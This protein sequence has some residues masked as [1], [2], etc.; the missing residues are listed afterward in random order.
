M[1][2]H[3]VF[4]DLIAAYDTVWRVGLMYKFNKIIG[5][6]KLSRLLNNMLTNKFICVPKKVD[7]EWIGS[8]TNII[9][10]LYA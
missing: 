6:S 1:K 2:T 8:I 9:Q 5:C 7:G 4:V 10:Y 3:L